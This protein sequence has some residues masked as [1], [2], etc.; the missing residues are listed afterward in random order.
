MASRTILAA[1]VLTAITASVLTAA[2]SSSSKPAA[3][4]GSQED[5]AFVTGGLVGCSP[6]EPGCTVDTTGSYTAPT[7]ATTCPDPGKGTT[8]G[9][10]D[11][12]CNGVTP[13]AVNA[14]SCSVL[15]AGATGDAATPDAAAPGPCGENGPDYGATMYGNEGDDDDC[16]YHT[17]WEA[18]PIC[19]SDGVYFIVKANYLTRS[20]APLTGACT[21]AEVCLNDTHP[22]PAVDSRPP[23]GNQ[24]VVEGPP[25]TYTVGPVV[26]D[27]A[28][29]W[30][31]R[32]HFNEICCDIAPDSP[33]GHAAFHVTVP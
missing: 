30:T 7:V 8:T 21:F 25:G 29:D 18:S 9:T 19:E 17:T 31:V 24:T 6:L 26:F 4:A 15:D 2:C 27:E 33:H 3:D 13:Q 11:S 22:G 16:K 14:L 1:V 20:M 32:F 23:Q 12:H 10:A 28:G 5:A